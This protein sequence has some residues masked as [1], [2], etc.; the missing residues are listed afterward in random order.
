MQGFLSVIFFI[1][2]IALIVGAIL[3]FIDY[4]QKRSKK[5]SLIIIGAAVVVGIV[6][7]GGVGM[8]EQHNANVEKARQAQVAGLKKQKDKK[9]KSTASEYLAEYYTAFGKS[10]DLGNAINKEWAQSIQDSTGDYDVNKALET[11]E[12]KHSTTIS[13]ITN[14]Q[15]NMDDYLS[16]LKKNDTG[17]YDLKSFETANNKMTD[18][19]TMVTTVSGSY[20]SFGNDFS[21][22]DDAVAKSFKAITASLE[23]M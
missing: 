3:F 1:A 12:K 11:I 19:T 4:A 17:K 16:T 10:E 6:S 15:S 5:K 13:E 9:F 2:L 20:T 21:D 14:E 18:L 22:S 8:I 7:L 23:E